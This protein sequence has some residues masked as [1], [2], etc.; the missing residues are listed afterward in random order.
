MTVACVSG[1]PVHILTGD[2][3]LCGRPD[4][5]EW[6][7]TVADDAPRDQLPDL[8]RICARVHYRTER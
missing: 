3:T 2:M 8:C 5:F 7:W 4:T 1:G 6:S